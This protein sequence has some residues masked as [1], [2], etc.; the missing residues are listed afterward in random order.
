VTRSRKIS[1]VKPL[2][3]GKE[4][5]KRSAL[6]RRLT[7]RIRKSYFVRFHMVLILSAT[8]ISG[9]ICSKVLSMMG[10]SRMSLRY[11]IAII[12]SYLLFF[13]FVKL[14]LLYIGMG[15]LFRSK[16]DKGKDG[17]SW[18]DLI[19][20]YGGAGSGSGAP[21]FPGFGGGTSGGGGAEGAFAEGNPG[22][23]VP[24][25]VGSNP[26]AAGGS[27]G[28]G[29]GILD[30]LSG[31]GD[32]GFLK[33]LAIVLLAALVL[34]VVIV[35]GY[36]IWSAPI[37]LSDAAFHV[38]LVAGLSRKVKRVK[39]SNW[40]MSIFKATWWGFLLILFAAVAFG[41]AAQ[42]Y[43]PAAITVKDLFASAR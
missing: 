9:V 16:K 32:E 36:L 40:E 17:S 35:G 42:L 13:F 12:V 26:V 8:V 15:R 28:G 41:I 4:L 39:E 6:K 33:I 34:S 19:P 14:W 30:G 25:G 1:L 21:R 7:E 20:S 29:G 24:V 2:M 27:H 43:K 11:G 37:I 10:V 18:G 3:R 5:I 22:V 31:F 23:A 38:L